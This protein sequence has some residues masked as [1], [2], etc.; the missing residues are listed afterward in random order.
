MQENGEKKHEGKRRG[1]RETQGRD[2]GGEPY[3]RQ[4]KEIERNRQRG[5]DR[6]E[7]TEGRDRG[8]NKREETEEK[9]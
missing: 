7:Q 8:A 9:R 5:T 2:I 4:R 6:G 3:K 1:E